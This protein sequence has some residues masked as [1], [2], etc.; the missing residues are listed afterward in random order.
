MLG[1]IVIEKVWERTLKLV[2]ETPCGYWIGGDY[3]YMGEGVR[4]VSKT[5]RKRYAYPT[6]EEAWESYRARKERQVIILQA[7]LKKAKACLQK[8]NE[9]LPQKE[10]YYASAHRL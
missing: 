3:S 4:W 6:R 2:K 9:S 7:K 5:S 10:I 1:S 8:A